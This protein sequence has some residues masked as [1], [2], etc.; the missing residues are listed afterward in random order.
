MIFIA[1]KLKH[2]WETC[3]QI[4]GDVLLYCVLPI[5]QECTCVCVCAC[6]IFLNL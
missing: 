2:S 3:D 6:V 5:D 4:G 1:F